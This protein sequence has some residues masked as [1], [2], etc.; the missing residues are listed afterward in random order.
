MGFPPE[1]LAEAAANGLMLGAVYALVALGLTLVY[2]VLHVV[3]FA[4]GA[5]LTLAL[6]A[7]WGAHAALGLDPYAAALPLA[8]LF[9]ALG[10][11][12]QRLVVGPA[13]RGED[14]GALLVTLG[15]AVVLENLL[16]AAFRSDTRSVVTPLADAVV[17]VGP[18]ILPLPRVVG[19]GAAVAVALALFAL[20][21]ATDAGRAMRA[22]AKERTGAALVGIDPAHVYALTFG[23]GAACVAVAACLL[24]PSYY[25]N[26]R[27]GEAF[28]LVAFTVVVLGGM[29]SVPGALAG[30]LL[31]GLV[32]SLTG[33]YLGDS[34]GQLGV[35]ALFIAVLLARPTGLFGAR[36]A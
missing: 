18:M 5:T 29:G 25:V 6:Y 34:L 30:G 10:Y 26:P 32:E 1:I 12:L 20:L 23:V 27:A 33:L 4:H 8:A 36:A 7:A 24:L 22:V 31:V 21:T 19:F 9:F 11:A 15:V 28:V 16:L 14:T 13:A 3:N 35:F 17:E 2:G